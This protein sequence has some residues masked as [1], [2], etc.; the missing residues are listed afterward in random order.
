MFEIGTK[1]LDEKQRFNG[2]KDGFNNFLKL[3]GH[4]MREAHPN[5]ATKVV[6]IFESADH[7]SAV[8][9]TTKY[10]KNFGGTKPADLIELT[11]ARN[12]RR[13]KH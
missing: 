8:D 9:Q 6:N 11:G 10:F 4:K 1:G 3:I 12:A 7:G 13:L 2:R 5:N